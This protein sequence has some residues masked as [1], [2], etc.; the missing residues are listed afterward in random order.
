MKNLGDH[1]NNWLKRAASSAPSPVTP[2]RTIYHSTYHI[3]SRLHVNK[4]LFTLN[5]FVNDI[6]DV[7]NAVCEQSKRN[8]FN[9]FLNGE[10]NGAKNVKCVQGFTPE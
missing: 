8:A 6:F 5:V 9:T 3:H 7:F 4:T 10:K 2:H 1:A